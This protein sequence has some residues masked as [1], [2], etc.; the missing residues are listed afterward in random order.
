M[1]LLENIIFETSN[2]MWAVSRIASQGA[3][4]EHCDH[5]TIIVLQMRQQYDFQANVFE[6]AHL[7][8]NT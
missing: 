1:K 6:A 7:K 3:V 5:I 2:P 8:E 4:P